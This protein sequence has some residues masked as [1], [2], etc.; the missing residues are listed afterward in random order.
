[1]SGTLEKVQKIIDAKSISPTIVN[2]SS[3]FVVT[4]YWWG[5]G[6]KNLN[7]ARP[8]VAFYEIFLQQI[9]KIILGTLSKLDQKT[10]ITV[11]ENRKILEILERSDK[12]KKA[13][14]YQGK[15]YN[16]MI[17]HD[18]DINPK[19]SVHDK[20][21]QAR[22]KLNEIQKGD[23]VWKGAKMG[24]V[25]PAVYSFKNVKESAAFFRVIVHE[26]IHQCKEELVLLNALNLK[27]RQHRAEESTRR[28]KL[29]PSKK[30]SLKRKLKN[31]QDNIARITDALKKKMKDKTL[32]YKNE[33]LQ[34]HYA[35][36]N[37]FDIMH[38]NLQYL[39]PVQFEEMIAKWEKACSD[40]NCNYMAVEYPEFAQPGGYQLAINAKPMFIVKALEGC[41]KRA[42]VYI[43]GDMFIRQYPA[44][45]DRTEYDFMA[46][47]WNMDPRS[48]YNIDTSITYDPYTFETSGGIQWFS[49]N[50]EAVGLAKKWVEV[51]S[52]KAQHGK[53]DDRILSLL[54]NTYKYLCSLKMINLPVEYLWLTLDYD[55]RMIEHIYDW[56]YNEME[57]TKMIEHSEC[58]TTEESAASASGTG[59][60]NDRQAK[61]YGFLEEN[62]DPVSEEYHEYLNFDNEQQV[63]SIKPYLNYMKTRSYIN[64]GEEK[65]ILK[66]FIDPEDPSDESNEYPLYITNYKDK[67]GNRPY[68]GDDE[69]TKNQVAEAN[70]KRASN[71]NVKSLNLATRKIN[72]EDIVIIEDF[73]QLTQSVIVK[74]ESKAKTRSKKSVT[75][76]KS[77]SRSGSQKKTRSRSGSPKKSST[78]KSSNNSPVKVGGSRCGFNM[79][80]GNKDHK[81]II[82]LIIRLLDE[83]KTVLYNPVDESGYNDKYLNLLITNMQKLYKRS[84]FVYVPIF[85]N[86]KAPYSMNYFY[87]AEMSLNQPIL[88]RPS[89]F[90]KK[91]LH[92]F[93]SLEDLSA[94]LANGSYEFMS[95]TR[96][97]YIID[98]KEKDT[99]T[100]VKKTAAKKLPN[101]VVIKTKNRFS[102]YNLEG[103]RKNKTKKS[104]LKSN[105][106]T[107]IKDYYDGMKSL[108]H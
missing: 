86:S 10:V 7:T 107:V 100:Q 61:F 45:F 68:F 95:N 69:V 30:T 93:L 48:S 50:P 21:R 28:D 11:M 80:G 33:Y 101:T 35:G 34:T 8:C 18:L 27:V 104:P 77:G 98:K 37:M 99:F 15:I 3:N 84:E 14:E 88:F 44:I 41:G 32:T 25:T 6:N 74:A 94:Y 4:T 97:G 65:L 12:Y 87:K 29:T 89:E 72:G 39:A 26:Y 51:S 54:I 16:D 82:S 42:V 85:N 73:G 67:Y 17:Y 55:D 20:E 60:G 63:T 56:D 53:A 36:K 13:L 106:K 105:K 103:G 2:P 58:L 43:D 49:Q 81:K 76:K 5:R 108:Y 90:L 46:R 92:M 79:I 22:H 52:T 1:M 83:N 75:R 31:L 40:N 64:D 62:I 59:S 19:N 102:G 57:Q 9:Q 96:V 38:D 91:F 71:M 23:A 24:G 70:K 47:G 66:G 78:R